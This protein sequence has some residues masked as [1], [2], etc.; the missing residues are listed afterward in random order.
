[1]AFHPHIQSLKNDLSA[2]F[3]GSDFISI[4]FWCHPLK[5]DTCDL[6][7]TLSI[8]KIPEK[9]ERVE[10]LILQV[11]LELYP[12]P[13][14]ILT[15]YQKIQTHGSTTNHC[16]ATFSSRRQRFRGGREDIVGS[17]PGEE[18]G[19]DA[20]K[21]GSWGGE[22]W[23]GRGR[24]RLEEFGGGAATDENMDE[25]TAPTTT[26]HSAEPITLQWHTSPGKEY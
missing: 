10:H 14:I 24:G 7:V 1:M 21:G 20:G 13:V 3:M 11:L 8:K 17:D 9:C 15:L 2:A 5:D 25:S 12:Q 16:G 19:V 22:N 18:Q 23:C 4:I 26:V 6:P